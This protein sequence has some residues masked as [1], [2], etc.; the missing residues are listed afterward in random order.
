MNVRYK[1]LLLYYN[2][3]CAIEHHTTIGVEELRKRR[4]SVLNNISFNKGKYLV[5]S[6]RNNITIIPLLLFCSFRTRM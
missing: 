2:V 1:E 6:G 4:L 5:L 3:F